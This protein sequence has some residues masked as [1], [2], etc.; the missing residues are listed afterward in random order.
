MTIRAK[1]IDRDKRANKEFRGRHTAAAVGTG[2]LEMLKNVLVEAPKRLEEQRKDG[3]VASTKTATQ[4][5]NDVR[6][7]ATK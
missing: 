4:P 3:R 5:V 1:T 6:R 2:V 7:V